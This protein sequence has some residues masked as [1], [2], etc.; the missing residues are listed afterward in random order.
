MGVIYLS[1]T[2]TEVETG[3]SRK[4][5]E[6]ILC[7]TDLPLLCFAPRGLQFGHSHGLLCWASELPSS[8]FA[9]TSLEVESNPP[10]FREEVNQPSIWPWLKGFLWVSS[11]PLNPFIFPVQPFPSNAVSDLQ[12]KHPCHR[13]RRQ[14][15]AGMSEGPSKI[16]RCRWHVPA[17]SLKHKCSWI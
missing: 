4:R 15:P 8:R 7:R 13:P 3:S 2:L 1:V 14:S 9:A 16:C 11:P 17:C 12:M 5:G 10:D 6:Q